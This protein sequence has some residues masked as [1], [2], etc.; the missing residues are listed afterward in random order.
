MTDSHHRQP[1]VAIALKASR[2]LEPRT[3]DVLNNGVVVV[4]GNR[5]QSVTDAAPA[6]AQVI[7]LGDHTVLPGLIDCHTHTL[8]RPED[9]V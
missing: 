8:L 3:G 2:V 9:Q 4:R 5:I 1:D 6:E 7:D